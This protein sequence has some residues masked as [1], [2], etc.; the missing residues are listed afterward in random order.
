M[1]VCRCKQCGRVVWFFHDKGEIK[2][3]L[4]N[5][6]TKLFRLCIDCAIKLMNAQMEATSD[7]Q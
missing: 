3:E 2:I 1:I 5:G 4:K 7:Q 6:K